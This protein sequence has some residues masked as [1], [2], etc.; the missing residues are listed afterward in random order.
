M[1]ENDGKKLIRVCL[2]RQRCYCN[3]LLKAKILKG[4]MDYIFLKFLIRES[5]D[6]YIS[7]ECKDSR[8]IR[9]ETISIGIGLPIF[10]TAS[11]NSSF[12]CNRL[13]T[14]DTCTLRY[15]VFGQGQSGF[16]PRLNR[17]Y[18]YIVL[19]NRQDFGKSG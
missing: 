5:I 11:N 18:F 17:S 4:I 13:R 14:R 19:L 3:E 9:I 1:V 6:L 15:R 16:P 12:N 2:Y 8:N 7:D 10:S